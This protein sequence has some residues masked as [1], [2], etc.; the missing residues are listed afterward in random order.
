MD[1]VAIIVYH[2]IAVVSVFNLQNISHNTVGGETPD[3]VEPGSP[4]LFRVFISVFFQ[5][6]LIKV[7]FKRFAKLISAIRVRDHFDDTA[8]FFV[9]PSSIADTL[10]RHHIQVQSFIFKNL[11]EKLNDLQS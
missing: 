8:K 11:L 3:E 4:K 5:E 2:D 6:V 7:D 1:E 10:V 9:L